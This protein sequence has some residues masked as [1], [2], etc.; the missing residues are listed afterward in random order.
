MLAQWDL[1]CTLRGIKIRRHRQSTPWRGLSGGGRR[2]CLQRPEVR[3]KLWI[4]AVAMSELCVS[5]EAGKDSWVRQ[6]DGC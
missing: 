6:E 3:E 4:L 1:P 5:D 2:R